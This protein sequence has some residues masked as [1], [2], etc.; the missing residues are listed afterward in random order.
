[1]QLLKKKSS[2]LSQLKDLSNVIDM[3]PINNYEKVI[4]ELLIK[5]FSC[6]NLGLFDCVK[7]ANKSLILDKT[8]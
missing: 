5:K 4:L 6:G 8:N 7:M 1:M 2:Y 3:D